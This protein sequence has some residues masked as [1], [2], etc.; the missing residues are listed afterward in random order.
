MQTNTF[1][2]KLYKT[3]GMRGHDV[4]TVQEAGNAG[5]P[6]EEVLA[7]AIRENRAVLTVN[8]RD[9][10]QLHKLKPDHCGIIACTR[11][12]D[13]PRLSANINNAISMAEILTGRVIRVYRSGAPSIS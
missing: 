5:L 2:D 7:F 1:P 6:D 3:C 10:F 11:D 12:D 8:R 13:L 4:L 9:F